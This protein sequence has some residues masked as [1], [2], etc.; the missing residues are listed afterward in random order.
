MPRAP[1]GRACG[2]RGCPRCRG[3]WAS[4]PASVSAYIPTVSSVLVQRQRKMEGGPLVLPALRPDT[5]AVELDELLTDRQAEAG[6]ARAPRDGVVQLLEGL[7]QAREVLVAD[8]DAG[9]GHAD[10]DRLRLGDHAHQHAPLRREL[11]RV[12]QKVEQ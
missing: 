3:S 8:P 9:V 11:D 12:R 2:S 5:A 7:E 4:C 1:R 6:P 10:V